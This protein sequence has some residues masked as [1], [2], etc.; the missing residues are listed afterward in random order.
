M[1]VKV[2]LLMKENTG[3]LPYSYQYFLSSL[4]YSAL[5]KANPELSF[6][7]H[8]PSP[9][10]GFVFSSLFFERFHNKKQGIY[11]EGK[12]V[13][14]FSSFFK[15]ITRSFVEG[16]LSLKDIYLGKNKF[17]LE[18]I[19]VLE[20]PDFTTINTFNLLSPLILQKPIKIGNKLKGIDLFPHDKDFYDYLLKNIKKRYEKFYGKSLSSNIFIEFLNFKPKRYC[21]KG[22]YY[23][24]PLGTLRII[25]PKD[26]LH[27]LYHTGIGSKNSM[28]FG[29]LAPYYDSHGK[30]H[31]NKI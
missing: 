6:Y 27:L 1:R 17:D 22:E 8:D 26:V 4:V 12:V 13:F 2:T 21:I 14:Y 19:E 11:F 20:D 29:M 10:K 16:I 5:E 28:G 24:G 18:K 15:E 23:R 9:F 30:Q 25:A 7:L 31:K 3:F